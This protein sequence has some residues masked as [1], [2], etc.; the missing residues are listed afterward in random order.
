ME[1][2]YWKT[3]GLYDHIKTLN[4]NIFT[5]VFISVKCRAW[6]SN[7]VRTNPTVYIFLED[8]GKQGFGTQL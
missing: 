4:I 2:L 7:K 6:Q 5:V 3:F 1:I 8:H